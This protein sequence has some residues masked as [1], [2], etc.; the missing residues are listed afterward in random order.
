MNGLTSGE[1]V[2][3][4]NEVLPVAIIIASTCF[5][6]WLRTAILRMGRKNRR[7]PS[8]LASRLHGQAVPP[9]RQAEQIGASAPGTGQAAHLRVVARRDEEATP[10]YKG[11]SLKQDI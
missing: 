1:D 10:I 11:R 4:S 2:M 8:P 9:L 6:C 7:V 5:L 3:G